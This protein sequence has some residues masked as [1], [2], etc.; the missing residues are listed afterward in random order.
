V[1]IRD[2]GIHHRGTERD[3]HN[4]DQCA[5]A[6][7]EQKVQGARREKYDFG[8]TIYEGMRWQNI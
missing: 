6:R 2:H 5:G 4:P 7:K 1:K 8:F 3:G